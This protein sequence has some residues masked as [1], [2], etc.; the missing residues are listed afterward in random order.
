MPVRETLRI[1]LEQA[2]DN[3]DGTISCRGYP[4]AVYPHRA[5]GFVTTIIDAIQ[6]APASAIVE[7]WTQGARGNVSKYA[8]YQ[9]GVLP[10]AVATEY[11]PVMLTLYNLSRDVQAT[12][13]V[14]CVSYRFSEPGP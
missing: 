7:I 1:D 6:I 5:G 9:G 2:I 11:S 13:D 12:L 8:T 4:L 10:K 3:Q 14:V